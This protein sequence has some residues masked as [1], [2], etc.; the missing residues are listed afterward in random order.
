MR[1]G[2]SQFPNLRLQRHED[3]TT[4]GIPDVSFSLGFV[5]NGDNTKIGVA[6]WIELKHKHK[7]PAKASTPV[8]FD[9]YTPEQKLFLEEQGNLLIP[10]YLFVQVDSDYFLFDHIRGQ[11]VGDLT[12]KQ[13]KE[14]AVLYCHKKMD[15][16]RLII[17]LGT[18]YNQIIEGI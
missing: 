16:L 3:T 15:W 1:L 9:H 10:A 5:P 13:M 2:L 4:V 11:N 7:Y 14:Q 6:G 12:K 17:I 8:R 18:P